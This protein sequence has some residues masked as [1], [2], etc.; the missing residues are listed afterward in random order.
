MWKTSTSFSLKEF[1]YQL[2][3]KIISWTL[4]PHI[5]LG[6]QSSE[7]G[8]V[9]MLCCCG[10]G[11]CAWCAPAWGQMS[12][13]PLI[14]LHCICYHLHFKQNSCVNWRGRTVDEFYAG[15]W[16]M[17]RPGAGVGQVVQLWSSCGPN[18]GKQTSLCYPHGKQKLSTLGCKT[19]VKTQWEP[20][21]QKRKE[22]EE[23]IPAWPNYFREDTE[24]GAA[25]E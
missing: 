14:S 5:F 18:A 22:T 15:V 20:T 13:G 17:C 23:Y 7:R 2:A 21:P 1:L 3:K 10:K 4:S 11:S 9:F 8:N 25:R 6:T 16:E 24:H 19:H 12:Y